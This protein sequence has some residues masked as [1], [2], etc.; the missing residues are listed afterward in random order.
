MDDKLLFVQFPHPGGEQGQDRDRAGW[1]SWNRGL[2]RRKFLEQVGTYVGGAKA[3]KILFWGEWEPESK[4]QRIE[5]PLPC[6]PRFIHEPRYVLPKSYKGLQNT[7]PFVFGE[8]FLYGFC[9]QPSFRQLSNL[10][11]GSIILF[12]SC[13]DGGFV[14]DTLFVV[15]NRQ[16]IDHAGAKDLEGRIP[17]EYL[18]VTVLPWYGNVAKAKGCAKPQKCRLYF[19]AT[20]ENRVH[21]MFSFFPCQPDKADSRGFVRPQLDPR[22][23]LKRVLNPRK[24]TGVKYS[25]V[26]GLTEMKSVWD[27]VVKQVKD[28]HLELG[29]YAEMPKKCLRSPCPRW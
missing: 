25:S 18:E 1:K 8:G 27:D 17:R 14:L 2:H 11:P 26:R 21:G 13:K 19:G 24:C 4:V 22:K 29:V 5:N 20:L 9:K 7:D 12:G 10:E 23:K 6:G 3:E 28:N 15:G 16:R